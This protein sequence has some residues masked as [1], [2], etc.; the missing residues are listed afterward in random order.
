M[1]TLRQHG[2]IG[3]VKG[4][5]MFD[6]RGSLLVF[7]AQPS[8]SYPVD[9]IRVMKGMFLWSQEGPTEARKLFHFEPYDF[10]P[11]DGSIYDDLEALEDSGY[12]TVEIVRGT[13]QRR[14][15]LTAEGRARAE[16]V[17]QCMPGAAAS[18]LRAINRHVTSLGFAPLLKDIYEK[19]PRFATNSVARV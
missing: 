3:A 8:G 19:Y 2:S 1:F 17:E 15:Q 11:F 13:R 4:S 5:G 7:L 14:F 18:Q 12:I 9:Q 6:R 10:G 16:A